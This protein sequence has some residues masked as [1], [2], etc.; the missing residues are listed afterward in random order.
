[1]ARKLA[2]TLERNARVF[3][4]VIPH[5]LK[6]APDAVLLVATNPVDIITT[7]VTR[8][9]GLPPA[10]V[11]GSGTILDTARFRTLLGERDYRRLAAVEA[12]SPVN[13]RAWDLV[14]ATATLSAA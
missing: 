10:R 9:S 12:Y 4:E 5:V 6:H 3:Q 8:I 7:L 13:T 14:G 11:I 2:N 1:M